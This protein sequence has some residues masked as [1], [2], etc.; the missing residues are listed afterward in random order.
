MATTTYHEEYINI[1]GIWQYMLHYSKEGN[2]NVLLMLHGGP[3][4]PNSY[5]GYFLEPYLNFC[6]VVYYDQRGAGKTQIKSKT[7]IHVDN[8]TNPI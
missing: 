4:A 3:G 1:N 8:K 5:I 6:N 2:R 7:V